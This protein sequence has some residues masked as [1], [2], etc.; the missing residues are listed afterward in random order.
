MSRPL[1]Y[2]LPP[3]TKQSGVS[4]LEV[5]IALLILSFGLLGL[6]S[7]QMTTLRSNLSSYDSSRAIMSIYSISDIMR[8]EIN[9]QGEL[10]MD[11]AFASGRLEGWE[12]D[13]KANLGDDAEGSIECVETSTIPVAGDPF[14]TNRCIVTVTWPDVQTATT[15]TMTTEVQL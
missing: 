9:R 1:P 11:N 3:S 4:L 5:L 8:A 13:L 14:I 2:L 7:L 6:A 15:R 10:D 12:N